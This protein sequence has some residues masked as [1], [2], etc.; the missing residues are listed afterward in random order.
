MRVLGANSEQVG[1]AFL[2]INQIKSAGT[3]QGDELNQLAEAGVPK[4]KVY[5]ELAKALGKTVPEILKLKEA[6]K[7][8]SNDAINAIGSAMLSLSGGKDF[9]DAGGKAARETL[10]GATGI[11][12]AGWDDMFRRAAEGSEGS[13]VAALGPIATEL[14]QLFNDP[15]FAAGIST[16][17]SGIGDFIREATPMVKDFLKA[18]GSGAGEAF[19]VLSDAIGPIFALFKGDGPG[20]A[21]IIKT[22]GTALGQ[23]TVFAGAIIVVLGAMAAAVTV[24]FV[25]WKTFMTGL[26]NTVTNIMGSIVAPFVMAFE[27]IAAILDSSGMS[28]FDKAI[29]I[30]KAII[31]GV[32]GGLKA[33]AM[34]PVELIKGYATS[35]IQAAE[36][37]LGIR[38]PSKVFEQIG[39]NVGLGMTIGVDDSMPTVQGM[40]GQFGSS[41]GLDF[42]NSGASTG[43]S[44]S[45]QIN[46]TAAPGATREDGQAVGQG[47]VDAL[48]PFLAM[49]EGAAH[50]AGV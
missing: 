10:S 47:I 37:A 27:S 30:G 1:R 14:N 38:S 13:I 20:T 3:L 26:F 32:M 15:R 5:E 24:A 16:F 35:W 41:S 4:A 36:V 6:G 39:N 9:G 25:T 42:T 18:F 23:L 8:E 7:I 11:L 12:K 45:F 48:R 34:A 40:A 28:L 33:M 46:V 43:S 29:G 19:S 44:N 50:E 21:N 22:I 49:L 17:V 2:A 31:Q